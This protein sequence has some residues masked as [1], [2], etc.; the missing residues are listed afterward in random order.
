M[1]AEAHTELAVTLELDPLTPRPLPAAQDTAHGPWLCIPHRDRWAPQWAPPLSPLSTALPSVTAQEWYAH[2]GIL[3][4]V[5]WAK[6]APRKLS[7]H[8]LQRGLQGQALGTVENVLSWELKGL[9][10]KGCQAHITPFHTFQAKL[11]PYLTGRG[12]V[13]KCLEQ[14]KRKKGQRSRCAFGRIVP[15]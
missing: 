14:E 12:G 4:S 15:S 9:G 10:P 1:D 7:A 8:S 3:P 5:R 11:M 13:L 2:R 6:Q